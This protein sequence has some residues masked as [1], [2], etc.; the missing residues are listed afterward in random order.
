[1]LL[2]LSL[3]GI[4]GVWG[5]WGEIGFPGEEE[6][7]MDVPATIGGTLDSCRLLELD[8]RCNNIDED[9]ESDNAAL[10]SLIDWN[11]VKAAP[12]RLLPASAEA[13]S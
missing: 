2:A 1:M 6:V 12:V 5:V 3:D 10:E 13:R 9:I 8:E 11:L 7:E 4:A